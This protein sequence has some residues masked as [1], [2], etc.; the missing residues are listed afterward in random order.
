MTDNKNACIVDTRAIAIDTT[1]LHDQS[2]TPNVLPEPCQSTPTQQSENMVTERPSPSPPDP[3]ARETR[4]DSEEAMEATGGGMGEGTGEESDADSDWSTESESEY[5]RKLLEKA[6]KI[7]KTTKDEAIHLPSALERL[8]RFDRNIGIDQVVLDRRGSGVPRLLCKSDNVVVSCHI[9][10][11]E[12][13]FVAIDKG[14]LLGLD[15]LFCFMLWPQ[16]DM[17]GTYKE[18]IKEAE[19]ELIKFMAHVRDMI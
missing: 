5:E 3:V 8:R 16:L 11:R 6:K 19:F 17:E 7:V 2:P 1:Q 12:K 4:S 15:V 10:T 13:E 18:L 14:S 9:G